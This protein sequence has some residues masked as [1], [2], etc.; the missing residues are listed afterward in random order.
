MPAPILPTKVDTYR[1]TVFRNDVFQASQ[2]RRINLVLETGHVVDIRFS[3]PSPGDWLT[4]TG[5]ATAVHMAPED[6]ENVRHILQTESPVYFQAL[7]VLGIR[8]ARVTTDPEPTGEGF[9]DADTIEALAAL[10]PK[11][12]RGGARR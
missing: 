10:L 2:R 6:Y 5:N 9:I 3:S 11:G 4:I 7:N 1:L 12:G 8:A